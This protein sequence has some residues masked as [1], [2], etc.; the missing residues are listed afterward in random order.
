[1]INKKQVTKIDL[2]WLE[3]DEFV[4]ELMAILRENLKL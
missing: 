1:M 3:L 4:K 2:D